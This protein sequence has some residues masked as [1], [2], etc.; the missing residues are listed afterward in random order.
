MGHLNRAERLKPYLAAAGLLLLFLVLLFVLHDDGR[1]YE[2]LDYSSYSPGENGVKAFYL[3]LEEYGKSQGI[4]VKRHAKYGRFIADGSFVICV[5]P[6][7]PMT[8]E[9]ELAAICRQLNAGSAY[10]ITGADSEIR[11]ILK[12]HI[13]SEN[14]RCIEQD[15]FGTLYRVGRGLL[16]DYS[17]SGLVT[18]ESLKKDPSA[19]AR[20]LVRISELCT[21]YGYDTV[22]F[23]EYYLGVEKSAVADI[24]GMGVILMAA[25]ICVA[26]LLWAWH[27]GRRLGKPEPVLETVRRDELGQ[28]HALAGLYRRIGS[29]QIAFQVHM[30]AL[31]SDTAAV[32]GMDRGA[33]FSPEGAA[34]LREAVRADLRLC[35]LGLPKLFDLYEQ[36]KTD[37]GMLRSRTVKRYIEE[38]ERI[39][40]EL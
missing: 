26:L 20:F 22:Y 23:N 32:L 27:R 17:D 35:K 13:G 29:P 1:R 7:L 30:E 12:T 28:V 4:A 3:S 18:T 37:S 36:T 24:I 31:M 10:L 9:F 8:Y 14:M 38:I 2:K 39:R 6:G 33:C 11:E 5:S 16:I 40:R 25:E 21:Q 15:S 34:Q 19:G